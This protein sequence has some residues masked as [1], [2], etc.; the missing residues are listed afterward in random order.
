MK[1]ICHRGNIGGPLPSMENKPEY[2]QV[3]LNSGFDVEIDVWLQSDGFY[4]GH[5]APTYKIDCSFL[6][7]QRLWVHCKNIEAYLELSKYIDINCF[8][9]DNEEL[10][11][12]TRGHLWAHSKCQKWNDNTVIVQ[13]GADKPQIPNSPLAI[14][15]DYV[16]ED[17]VKYA[18]PFDLLI[19]DIDGIM[20]DGTKMYDRDGKVFGKTYCDLD[21][22]AIKRFMAAGVKV[23]FLSGDLIVNKSMAETRKIQFF[24]NPPGTDKIDFLSNIKEHFD[25]KCIAYVGDDYYDIAIMCA[26][27]FAFCPQ[28][29][30]NA[31][32]R[33]A[34]VLNV[35]AGKGVIAKLYDMVE[36]KIAYAFPMDAADVNPK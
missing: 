20:T 25:A 27:D 18:P 19:I 31:V 9:Q 1:Y 34:Q 6:R 10:V 5:D 12:T 32:K 17:A 15:S 30:P 36:D 11:A 24:H 14:C 28:T 21:F 3:A 16:G 29:S 2:I 33:I 23:C 35:D 7:N 26:V 22:T 13:L 8:F 4:L